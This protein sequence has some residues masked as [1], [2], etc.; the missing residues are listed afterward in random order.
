MDSKTADPRVSTKASLKYRKESSEAPLSTIQRKNVCTHAHM[1]QVEKFL[2]P[3][4]SPSLQYLET[5]WMQDYC[6]K[7]NK[8]SPFW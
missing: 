5:N 3:K 2:A 4:H 8:D 7:M 1:D 6:L